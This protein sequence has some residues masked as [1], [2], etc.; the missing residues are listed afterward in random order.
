M[1]AAQIIAVV[2]FVVMFVLVVME[3]IEKHYVTLGCGLLTL[4]LVFGVAMRDMNAV[5][6][7]LNLKSMINAGF[8]IGEAPESA[9]IDWAT[10][11][12]LGGMMS[13]S[14]TTIIIKAYDD[15]GI[16]DKPYAAT[17]FGLLVMEDLIAVLMMV[18]FSTMALTHK[19]S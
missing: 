2:I 9:G 4:G 1:L 19:V 6:E 7:T 3:K 15:L 8:W 18:M 10:I 13:M 14:S 17:V 12:F 5:V 11:I 16:K